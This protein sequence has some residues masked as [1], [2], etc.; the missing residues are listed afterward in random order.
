MVNIKQV[1]HDLKYLGLGILAY[2]CVKIVCNIID[3]MKI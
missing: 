1:K 3:V 2:L